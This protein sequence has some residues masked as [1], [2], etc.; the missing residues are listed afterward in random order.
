[1][2]KKWEERERAEELVRAEERGREA[3]RVEMGG[4]GMSAGG[5]GGMRGGDGGRGGYMVEGGRAGGG[6]GYG[7]EGGDSVR[8]LGRLE[9]I[10]FFDRERDED[11]RWVKERER[12]E[13]RGGSSYDDF[14]PRRRY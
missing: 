4:M 11:M 1:M 2:D 3:G 14:Q 5:M 8:R 13:R 7:L 12:V 9:D 6:G 10:I